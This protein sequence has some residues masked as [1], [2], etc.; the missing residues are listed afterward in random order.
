M[1]WPQWFD[2]L[3]KLIT[4]IVMGYLFFFRTGHRLGVRD[5]TVDI[6]IAEIDRFDAKLAEIRKLVAEAG[7]RMSD[8]LSSLQGISGSIEL[9][10]REMTSM[11]RENEKISDM[12]GNMR[13]RIAKCEARQ[14]PQ[15][16]R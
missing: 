7:K 6:K 16:Q 2:M 3:F 10:V 8:K 15:E 13:E 12:L 1:T 9:V 5:T 11:Q 4:V 14:W